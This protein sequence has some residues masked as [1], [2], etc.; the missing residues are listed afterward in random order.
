MHFDFLHIF[1]ENEPLP[2]QREEMKEWGQGGGGDG[3]KRE[4]ANLRERIN[5][6]ANGGIA[7][8]HVHSQKN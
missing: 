8:M 4:R 3:G 7:Y 1:E 2:G 5:E 6:R